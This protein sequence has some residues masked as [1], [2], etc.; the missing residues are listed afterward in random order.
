M[1]AR[2]AKYGYLLIYMDEQ[3]HRAGAARRR[4]RIQP[5]IEL[6]I[7]PFSVVLGRRIGNLWLLSIGAALRAGRQSL[8]CALG[9]HR[10]GCSPGRS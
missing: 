9:R 1:R 10:P 2:A 4:D 8:F 6:M 7:M 3:L 5:L